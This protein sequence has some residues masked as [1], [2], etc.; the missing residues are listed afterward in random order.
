MHK[1]F[2]NYSENNKNVCSLSENILLI[3]QSFLYV[4]IYYKTNLDSPFV[5]LLKYIDELWDFEIAGS[6]YGHNR[7]CFSKK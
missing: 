4:N 1:F 2:Y 6:Y 5:N 3:T 7:N